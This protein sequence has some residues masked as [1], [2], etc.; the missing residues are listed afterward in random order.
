M[1]RTEPT[2]EAMADTG[3]TTV[4]T[5]RVRVRRLNE[6]IQRQHKYKTEGDRKENVQIL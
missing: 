1:R 3:K 4:E 5:S 2:E 6:L